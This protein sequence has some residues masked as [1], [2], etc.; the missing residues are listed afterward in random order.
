MIRP[1]IK[2]R[3]PVSSYRPLL[4]WANEMNKLILA[5]FALNTIGEWVKWLSVLFVII[6]LSAAF[7]I[8]GKEKLIKK[9]IEQS[10]MI[11][12]EHKFYRVT[13]VKQ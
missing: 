8:D 9:D 12:I 13:E 10:S 5:Q 3:R 2:Q 7:G 6:M 4:L 1:I 11:Q